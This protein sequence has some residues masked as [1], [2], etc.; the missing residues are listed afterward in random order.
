MEPFA[1]RRRTVGMKYLNHNFISRQ[2]A[3]ADR[4]V[5]E[6]AALTIILTK[7]KH[8]DKYGGSRKLKGSKTSR[9][10]KVSTVC[11]HGVLLIDSAVIFSHDVTEASQ[12]DAAVVG[13][14]D[15]LQ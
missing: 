9:Q 14:R 13:L 4:P 15:Q 7:I 3:G 1:E 6:G 8:L 5:V 10:P 2:S 11:L 12:V